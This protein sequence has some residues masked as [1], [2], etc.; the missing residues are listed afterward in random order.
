MPKREELPDT[1]T[2]AEAANMLNLAVGTVRMLVSEGKLKFV[3][4]IGSQAIDTDSLV[5]YVNKKYGN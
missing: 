4:E 3:G 5:E 1:L 2:P